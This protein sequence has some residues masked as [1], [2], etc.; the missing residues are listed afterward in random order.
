M[1]HWWTRMSLPNR[2]MIFIAIGVVLGLIMGPATA[3]I[4]IVGDIFVNLIMM[5]VFLLVIPALISGMAKMENPRQIGNVGVTIM[6]V[7]LATTVIAGVIALVLANVFGPGTGLGLPLPAGFKYAKPTQTMLDVIKD[8][9][10][11]NAFGALSAGNLLAVLFVVLFLGAGVIS[12]K[13]KAKTLRVIFDEWTELSMKMLNW[14]MELAPFGAGALMAWSVGFHGPKVLGPLAFF[15]VIVY[16]GEILILVEYTI[17]MVA[18]GLRPLKF[19]KAVTEPALV[20][21]T[22]CS[23]M[24]TLGVNVKA[25]EKMG[26]PEGVA[27]FGITLGNV[28]NM[29]GTA[30]YQALAVVFVS[31]AYNI[32]LDLT[33]QIMVVF[34]ATV[35]TISLVGVPG[36]GTASL[37]LLLIAV[38]LPVEAIGLILAVDRICDMPRTMNNVIGDAMSV[39]VA[40]KWWKLLSPQSE[41]LAKPAEQSRPLA[42]SR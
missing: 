7:F 13:E 34:M 14:V 10:P 19:F 28:V 41:L 29:D 23:S 1:F 6:I 12:L 33:S 26:V 32:P 21:F 39:V 37:G 11:R 42:Q 40:S 16:L 30:L 22:T 24:A 20:S 35:V 17:I 27:T 25:T 9:V 8:I 36:A 15:V 4:K 38:G 18:S 2:I 3:S 31:Q 5:M